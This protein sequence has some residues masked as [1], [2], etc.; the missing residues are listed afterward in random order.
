MRILIIT[1]YFW[2]EDFRIN[3]IVDDFSKRGHEINILTGEPN[4]PEGYLFKDYIK[5]KKKFSSYKGCQIKRL[6]VFRRGSNKFSLLLNYISFVVYASIYGIF[7]YSK[8]DFDNIFVFEPSPITVC[9]PAIFIKY[10]T[11]TPL[12]LWVLDLWPQSLT[13]L[14]FIKN[15]SFLYKTIENL[16]KFIYKNCDLIL[17]Q[18]PS[19]VNEIKRKVTNEK[20]VK[21]FP[22]WC[23]SSYL[24]RSLVYANEI[25]QDESTFK[26]IFA[27]NIGEAQDFPTI[28]NAVASLS[29]DSPVRLYILGDGRKLEWVRREVKLKKLESKVFILGRFPSSRMNDFFLHADALLVSL[30]KD[31]IFDITI[32]G[33]LQSYLASSKPIIAVLNG[34]GKRVIDESMSGIVVEPENVEGLT[35]AFNKMSQLDKIEIDKMGINGFNYAQKHFKKETT[36]ELLNTWMEDLA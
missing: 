33:K 22:N 25:E 3:E 12:T 4:Y 36:L 23:E 27:G 17:G 30:K 1:Q 8:N 9:L 15:N 32:P 14:N 20:K 16:V 34:E 31:P 35:A 2:P 29:E 28:L 18:S 10:K 21:F 13:A 6:P 11:N 7:R 5:D 26:I 19:F 24:D